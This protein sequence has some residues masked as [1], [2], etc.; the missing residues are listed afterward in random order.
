MQVFS[1]TFLLPRNGLVK[2]L[3]SADC[4]IDNE[5]AEF[6]HQEQLSK[7]AITHEIKKAKEQRARIVYL[8]AL[9]DMKK[10][11][12][13]TALKSEVMRSPIKIIY[14]DWQGEILTLTRKMIR[15]LNW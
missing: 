7:G 11:D 1:G 8:K 13:K 9:D 3:K 5:L 14:L 15:L 6:K 12:L 4:L 2:Y 10:E